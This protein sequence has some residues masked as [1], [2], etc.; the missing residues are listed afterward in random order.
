MLVLAP[1]VISTTDDRDDDGSTPDDGLH[2]RLTFF[3]DLE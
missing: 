1:N 3:L 2:L